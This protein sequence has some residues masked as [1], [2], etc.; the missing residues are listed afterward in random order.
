[1]PQKDLSQY[2]KAYFAGGCFWCTE[3]DFE[4]VPGVVEVISGYAG[5]HVD[6]PSYEEVSGG[7]TGHAESIEVYY[8]PDKVTYKD[9]LDVFWHSVDPTDAG[10]QFCDRGSQYRSEIFY[11]DDEQKKAAEA[12]KAE[13]EKTKPFDAPIVTQIE[14][15]KHFWPAEDYHQNFY[16]THT[17]RYK[18][19]RAGCGRDARVRELWGD[20]AYHH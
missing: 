11:A 4:S 3:S 10:G 8:D 17:L 18:T 6:N 15:L 16:K 12:S 7:T 14:P 1:M 9:L 19:Y 5:G 20:E 13:I 2:S